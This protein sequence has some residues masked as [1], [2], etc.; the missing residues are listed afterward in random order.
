MQLFF[1]GLH[2]RCSSTTLCVMRRFLACFTGGLLVGSASLGAEQTAQ[3]RLDCL[4]LRFQTATTKLFGLSYTLELTTLDAQ[5]GNG[6]LA[7][8]FDPNQ[9]THGSAF[10]LTDPILA[11]T[12]TGIIGFDV[13]LDTDANGNNSPDFFEVNQGVSSVTTQ[14][15]FT[16]DA[17]GEGT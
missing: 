9:P 2:V 1:P 7:P 14:G 8:L 11:E 17:G 15:L 6:E 10:R 5:P 12:I 16:D 3:L 13:P 4:S